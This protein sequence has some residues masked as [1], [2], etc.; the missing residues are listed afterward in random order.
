MALIVSCRLA[1]PSLFEARSFDGGPAYYEATVLIPK[2]EDTTHIREAAKA[3]IT[4]KFGLDPPKGLRNPIRDG[5]AEDARAEYAGYW[6]LKVKSKNPPQVIDGRKQR[7]TDTTQVRSGDHCRVSC[8]A[9]GYDKN[10]NRGVSFWLNNV[11]WI[12][13]GEPIGGGGRL[14]RGRV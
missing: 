9:V 4:K 5:D 12:E 1:Y 13:A 3:A 14:V 6:Y 8:N 7:I 2:D 11:Q 10:G